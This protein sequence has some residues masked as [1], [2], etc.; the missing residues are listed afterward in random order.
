MIIGYMKQTV[1]ELWSMTLRV[2]SKWNELEHGNASFS[3]KDVN[4]ITTIVREIYEKYESDERDEVNWIFGISQD[5]CTM[6][7]VGSMVAWAELTLYSCVTND[8]ERKNMRRE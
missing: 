7:T 6:G 2:W 5:V 4:I 1:E 8:V 3:V